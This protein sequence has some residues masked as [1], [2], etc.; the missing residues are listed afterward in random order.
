[1]SEGTIADVLSGIDAPLADA[2]R[3]AFIVVPAYNEASVIGDVLAE[4]VELPCTVVVVD[5]GSSDKTHAACLDYPVALLRHSTNLGQGAALQTGIT[6]A[7]TSASAEYVVTF[8]ADGQ[9]DAVDVVNLVRCLVEGPY[10]VA[11]GS[12]FVR[13]ADARSIPSGRRA[14]L[15]CA[16]WFTRRT[17]GL[18]VSDTHN[19]LRAFTADAAACLDLQ[20]GGMAHASEILGTIRSKRLRWCEVPVSISYTEYSRHKGQRGGAAVNIVWDLI[21]GRIR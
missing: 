9:H 4:L 5:D 19:G 20:H 18:G 11:L 3:A 7:L 13:S 10:D 16:V 6:Y 15:R 1:M 12:R 14:L 8:D 2:L 17:S 21:M